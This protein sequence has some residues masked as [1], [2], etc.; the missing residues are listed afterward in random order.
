MISTFMNY[1]K[2]LLHSRAMN[3]Y[4]GLKTQRSSKR[5]REE[6]N[7]QKKSCARVND[8]PAAGPVVPTDEQF[9]PP[10]PA[11]LKQKDPPG[12]VLGGE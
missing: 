6:S 11:F 3:L 5:G 8:D 2:A 10:S 4:V 1:G 12:R 7:A 9:T